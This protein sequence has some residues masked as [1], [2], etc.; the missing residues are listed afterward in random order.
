MTEA[1]KYFGVNDL[2][3]DSEHTRPIGAPAP[4]QIEAGDVPLQEHSDL[5]SCEIRKY[6][7]P[8]DSEKL[9]PVQALLN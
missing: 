6:L 3:T 9:L 1:C 4:I 8:R 5:D 7:R 2:A